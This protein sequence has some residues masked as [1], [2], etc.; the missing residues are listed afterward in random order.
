MEELSAVLS[1]VEVFVI[2]GVE[3]VLVILD[4]MHRKQAILESNQIWTTFV[5]GTYW[6]GE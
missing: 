1:T 5:V 3:Q 6:I 4:V 2:D